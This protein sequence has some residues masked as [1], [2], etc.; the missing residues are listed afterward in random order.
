MNTRYYILK[1]VLLA[2]GFC[3]LITVGGRYLMKALP[4]GSGYSVTP[5]YSQSPFLLLPGTDGNL[6]V[7]LNPVFTP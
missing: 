5:T 2:I 3:L 6:T 4:E 7:L 1:P